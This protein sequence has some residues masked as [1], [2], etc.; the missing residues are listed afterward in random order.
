M[1]ENLEQLAAQGITIAVDDFGTG[2]SSLG[3]LKSLPLTSL[4]IDRVF[5]KDICS[6]ETD[7][8]IVRTVI[9]MAHTMG[10]KVVAEGVETGQ[11]F[12][13]LRRSSVDEIQG[14]LIGKPVA[15]EILVK[16]YLSPDQRLPVEEKVVRIRS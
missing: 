5:V 4:K 8:N 2:Y 1:L 10:I 11:Q 6:D 7:Q 13:L 15:P 12:E 14:Y 3:Y 9:S 16:S